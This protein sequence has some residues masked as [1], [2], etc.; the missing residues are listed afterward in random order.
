MWWFKVQIRER[1][2]VM[3][4]KIELLVMKQMKKNV[5][6]IVLKCGGIAEKAKAF[7]IVS[8][9][10]KVKWLIMELIKDKFTHKLLKHSC[11]IFQMLEMLLL[12]MPQ[13]EIFILYLVLHREYL[14]FIFWIGVYFHEFSSRNIRSLYLLQKI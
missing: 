11:P 13:N 8:A 2:K 3:K 6:V 10:L 4:N 1:E 9:V 14:N 12:E 7:E 5:I